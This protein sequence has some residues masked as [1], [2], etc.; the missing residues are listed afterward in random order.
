MKIKDM[1]APGVEWMDCCP[2]ESL[3]KY[4]RRLEVQAFNIGVQAAETVYG[5][6]FSDDEWR[7]IESM[8]PR[9]AVDYALR[10]LQGRLESSK[11]GHFKDM[12]RLKDSE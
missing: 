12:W 11:D 2:E 3:V 9:R 7:A 8:T 1:D 4:V 10:T 6:G 5:A